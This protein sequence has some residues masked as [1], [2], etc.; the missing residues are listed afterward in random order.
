MSN[1]FF[2]TAPKTEKMEYSSL[3]QSESSDSESGISTLPTESKK[4]WYARKKFIISVVFN[5]ALFILLA[6]VYSRTWP[7]PKPKRLL[8]SPVPDF[9]HEVTTF[10]MNPLYLSLPTPE[11]N[12]AWENL[13]GPNGHGFIMLTPEEAADYPDTKAGLSVFHQLHCLGAVR[14]FIWDLVLGR[15]DPEQLLREWPENVTSPTYHSAIHGLWH[16]SHCLDYLRQ[17]LQC[18]GDTSLEFVTEIS[19]EA[20]VDGLD[21]PHECRSWDSIWDYATD[22][23]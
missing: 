9:P 4:P 12:E 22:R 19:G 15:E 1:M 14:K 16:I 21:W 2:W 6:L 18:A 10:R 17:A 8:K 7:Q 23:A 20:V 3:K 11:S 5:V 13:P